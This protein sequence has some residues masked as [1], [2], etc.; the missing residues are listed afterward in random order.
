MCLEDCFDCFD[1][2]S[3]AT[4]ITS[5]MSEKGEVL[6]REITYPTITLVG[7][8]K[9]PNVWKKAEYKLSL[10]T[11]IVN[12]VHPLKRRE[13]I[14]IHGPNFQR[15]D[16]SL[17]I[18]VLNKD[19]YIGLDTWDEIFYAIAQGKH[20]DFLEPLSE[21]CEQAYSEIC[22]LECSDTTNM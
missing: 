21:E 19:G 1:R 7:S 14:Y 2:L 15:I 18:L 20:I 12:T 4:C 11:W 17:A 16:A 22:S 6:R 13:G 5:T 3:G 9:F 10:S 8:A